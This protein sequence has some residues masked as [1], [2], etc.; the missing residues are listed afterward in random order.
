[1]FFE[2][3]R[4]NGST[5][6]IQT[7]ETLES[8]IVLERSAVPADAETV[9]FHDEAFTA[10]T[11]EKG[12]FLMPSVAFCQ[13]TCLTFFREREDAREV[14]RDNDMP[15]F[16][17]AGKGKALL[18]VVEGMKLDYELVIGVKGGR[19][20]LYP[21]FLLETGMYENIVLRYFRLTGEEAT[22]AGMART[23]RNVLLKGGEVRPLRERVREQSILAE[24]LMG[25]QVRVRMG[26]KPMPPAVLEQDRN[27]P[28]AVH[29]AVTFD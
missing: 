2:I 12:F 6:R 11:G 24:S 29:V 17:R 4:K 9:S 14:F 22:P 13:E 26:W 3:R 1:M 5:Q 28:P 8:K 19:Y 16:A 10:Q 21:R 18:A 20:Y 7:Q 23:Y 25:P 15:L 27:D